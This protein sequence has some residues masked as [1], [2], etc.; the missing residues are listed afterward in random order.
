[1]EKFIRKLIEN[2]SIVIFFTAIVAAY[3]LYTYYVIPKQENPDTTV[4]AAVITTI[5]PGATPEDVESLVTDKIE[6]QVKTMDSVDYFT[7]MSM[8]SASVVV[9]MF[10]MDYT[11]DEVEQTLR[12]KIENIQG[13]LPDMC[14]PSTINT[15]VVEKN[16]FIIALSSD[17]YSHEELVEYAKTVKDSLEK[18][19]GVSSVEIDGQ[20]TRRVV[21]DTD[22]EKMNLYGVSIE[23]I[24]SL[25]QAQ[26]LSIPAGSI[27]Y[28]T[29]SINVNSSAVF[30]S[31]RD[32]ENVVVGGAE[33]SLS[34]VKLKDVAD[35]YVE[36][37]SDYYYNQDGKDAIL[38]TGL[39]EEGL[40]S[41]NVG[42]G[43]RK[44]IDKIKTRVPPQINF[45]EVMYAPQDTA[46]SINSFIVN[47]IESIALIV[48]V[49]MIGVQ[50]RN[51]LVISVALPMSILITFIVMNIFDIEFQFVSI[52]ALIVSLGILVDNA[53]VISEEIQSNLNRGMERMNA[54]TSAVKT[55]AMP[56]LTSTLT[57]IV[58]FGIIYF[59]PGTVGQVAGTIPTVVIAA[60]TASYVIAMGLIPVL[61]Y[62]FFKPETG[63]KKERLGG[64]KK[65]FDGLLNYGMNHKRRTIIFAFGTLLVAAL[66]V[67]QLGLQFFPTSAKPVIYINVTGETLSLDR[68][69]EIS[70]DIA[71]LLDQEEVVDHYTYSVGKGLPTFFLT[72][73]N[74]SA[75]DNAAQFM[76]QLN[77]DVL[78]DMGG[79]SRCARYIQGAIDR[80]I[81]GATVEVKCLEYSMPTDAK[82][83][84]SVTGDDVNA[85]N[86]AV[87]QISRALKEI[88]GTDYVR[89]TSVVPQ[90]QYKVNLDSE[91]LS[92]YGLLK[93]D[94]VKQLNTSLMGAVGSTFVTDGNEMDILVKADIDNLEQLK[95][96]P[97]VGS[98]ADTR[99]TLGQVSDISLETTVPL[100]RHYNG[101]QYVNV[102][103]DVLPGYSSS[104][105]E[106]TLNRDYIEN[107]DLEG[108]E[109]VSRGEVTNMMELVI[110]LAISGGFAIVIIYVILLLQFK[111][112]RKPLIILTSIPLSLIGSCFGLFILQMDLQVMALLGLVSLFGIV[113]NNGILLIEVIDSEI[114]RGKDVE[115]A[116][117]SAVD[118]RFRPIMLST[119]TTCI[120]LVPLIL[121]GDPMSA[122]MATVLLFGLLFSTILT[123]VCVPVLY[124]MNAERLRKK[125]RTKAL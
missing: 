86:R 9:V 71:G 90:Y 56:V 28:E 110:S 108:V 121:A 125:A 25:M 30:E 14:Q 81:A 27:D 83:T 57:T 21:V 18:V 72:V 122:P 75:A 111:D 98:V 8:N 107:M 58:T 112:F 96:M 82:I 59:V 120:G 20:P 6:E 95:N 22:V 100:I 63:K 42:K 73:P 113:V 76:L 12:Q 117:R 40:N 119:T 7:S 89:D 97:I 33:D 52:A 36:N 17:V 49:V 54:V 34:F 109:I 70:R 26:N 43:V 80:N 68:T 85:I 92:G 48:L 87:E 11:I 114:R 46:N 23:N 62:M 39:F 124:S 74:M 67:S 78:K 4:A 15:D 88:E 93:Y 44:A 84:L 60:L 53:I 13:D 35:V 61:G 51:G 45:H 1:M 31:L 115:S 103:S 47:L 102:L 94:V 10:K 99:V 91:T 41:V 118:Q 50:L 123:M 2:R 104:K 77:E 24:L 38:L 69:G 79:T 65:I 37:V 16:Q 29:G 116:C 19:D 101:K 5:Y 106:N 55:T 66:L 105:I 64:V 32:I 3:G